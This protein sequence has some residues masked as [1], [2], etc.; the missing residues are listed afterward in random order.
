MIERQ[1]FAWG[2]R[3]TV[4]PFAS[5][6]YPNLLIQSEVSRYKHGCGSEIRVTFSGV[7]TTPLRIV[8]AQI[9]H[10]AMG[11]IISETRTVAAEMKTTA[12]KVEAKAEAKAAKPKP[13]TLRKLV[14]RR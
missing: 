11:A 3:L 5:G 7:A 14:K 12:M 4:R 8:D 1:S 2:V 13:K 10:E 6:A 9:W